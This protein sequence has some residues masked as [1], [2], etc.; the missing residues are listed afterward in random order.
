MK[1]NTPLGWDMAPSENSQALTS[2]LYR[3]I[4]ENNV[5]CK[6]TGNML[7]HIESKQDLEDALFH[8]H[9]LLA[10]A[11]FAISEIAVPNKAHHADI[12]N[13]V[14]VVI[15]NVMGALLD[16]MEW[17]PGADFAGRERKLKEKQ[18]R[19]DSNGWF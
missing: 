6:E 9:D 19:G 11:H 2:A 15:K 8:C 4:R 13:G 7:K 10:L 16:A 3:S 17:L 18:G 5:D 14:A 1:S 12:C